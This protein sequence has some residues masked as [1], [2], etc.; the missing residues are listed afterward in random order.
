VADLFG[1]IPV[2]LLEIYVFKSFALNFVSLGE[3]E[4]CGVL[5]HTSIGL[6]GLAIRPNVE[7]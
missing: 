1:D 2:L 4:G 5:S 7:E 3:G 6:N